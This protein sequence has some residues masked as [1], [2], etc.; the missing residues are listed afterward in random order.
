MQILYFQ[1]VASAKV[2]FYIFCIF[3]CKPLESFQVCSTLNP[4]A[5]SFVDF[6]FKLK[7][8]FLKVYVYCIFPPKPSSARPSAALTLT[9][10]SLIV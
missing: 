5:F 10:D 4:A 2:I 8:S 1:M 3:A 6:H 9:L 7:L